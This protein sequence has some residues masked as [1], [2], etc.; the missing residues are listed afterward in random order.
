MKRGSKRKRSKQS[1]TE[2]YDSNTK[3]AR[4]FVLSDQYPDNIMFR[5]L[6]G[7][8]TFLPFSQGELR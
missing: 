3:L 4:F 7:V 6:S 2:V 8:T 5:A 1:K